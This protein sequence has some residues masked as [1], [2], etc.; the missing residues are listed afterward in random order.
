MQKNKK[1]DSFKTKF[2]IA[3]LSVSIFVFIFK[4]DIIRV[5]SPD[6]SGCMDPMASNYNPLASNDDDSCKYDETLPNHLRV[7]I[8]T[9]KSEKWDKDKYFLL[10]DK[11]KIHFSSLNDSGSRKEVSALENL[12]MAYMIVLNSATK[13]IVKNCF[14]S[15]NNLAK[16]VYNYYKKYKKENKEIYNAQSIF[17]KK[18]QILEKKKKVSKLLSKEYIKDEFDILSKEINDFKS[19][20]VYKK[21]E[22]C[23]NLKKIILDAEKDLSSFKDISIKF[24]IWNRN[25]KNDYSAVLVDD[26]TKF[27]YSKYKWYSERVLEEDE[28]LKE[29]YRIKQEKIKKK[30]EQQKKKARLELN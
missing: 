25:I 14:I 18:Y 30:L 26:Y 7:A 29:R 21:F 12:E 23:N 28:R 6:V 10:R 15:D 2:V 1:S 22:K 24:K 3:F 16:E 27:Q 17:K 13:N 5:L 19:L 4:T 8:E 11:I 20:S 9:F